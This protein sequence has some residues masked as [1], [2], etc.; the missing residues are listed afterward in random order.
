MFV[1]INCRSLISWKLNDRHNYIHQLPVINF[2]KTTWQAYCFSGDIVSHFLWQKRNNGIFTTFQ[3][4][5]T[6][7][8]MVSRKFSASSFV[9]LND[10]NITSKELLANTFME[11]NSTN[12]YILT[13]SQ[14]T[15]TRCKRCSKLTKDAKTTTIDN[16]RSKTP[17]LRQLT[18]F[19]WCLQ[20]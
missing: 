1:F 7:I 4:E 10:R 2:A 13:R 8:S 14:K 18:L 9:N 20:C 15:Y 16:R 6:Y 17:K 12:K 5:D 11:T 3:R 19:W